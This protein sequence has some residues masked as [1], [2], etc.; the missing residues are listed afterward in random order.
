[1]KLLGGEFESIK[2]ALGAHMSGTMISPSHRPSH[3]FTAIRSPLPPF[4]RRG[5][6]LGEINTS[7]AKLGKEEPGFES[8]FDQLS[9][10]A[11]PCCLP[12]A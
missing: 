8:R 1:M 10:S 5:N 4:R 6:R 2:G 12:Y 7:L 9:S 3:L 11:T